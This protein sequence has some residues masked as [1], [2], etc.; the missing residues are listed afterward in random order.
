[1]NS[2]FS[3]TFK[4]LHAIRPGSIIEIIVLAT[5]DPE[6]ADALSESW[7]FSAHGCQAVAVAFYA[8]NECI[9]EDAKE[10]DI[11]R[12]RKISRSVDSFSL[13]R[14]MIEM[15]KRRDNDRT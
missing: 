10:V 14:D 4:V 6:D 5:I 1:M 2:P 8:K 7:N 9:I 11:M 15:V 3:D 13:R 12:V